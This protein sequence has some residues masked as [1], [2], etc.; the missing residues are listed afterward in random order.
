MD[1]RN[2][3]LA[4]F[5]RQHGI[6]DGVSLVAVEI[7]FWNLVNLLLKVYLAWLVASA[8]IGAFLGIAFLV[9]MLLTN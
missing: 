5:D 9:F 3:A 1:E 4:E 8:I 2:R 6:P 7:G